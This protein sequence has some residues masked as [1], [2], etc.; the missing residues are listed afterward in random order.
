V[1][2]WDYFRRKER[3]FG[4][5]P[6]D[7]PLEE[8][9]QPSEGDDKRGIIEGHLDLSPLCTLMSY[10]RIVIEDESDPDP[11]AAYCY[12]LVRGGFHIHRWE[13]DSR[14]IRKRRSMSMKGLKNGA[15]NR[16]TGRVCARF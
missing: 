6:P 5:V 12:T 4:G 8:M 1:D 3:E 14:T 16:H 11:R 7:R 9:M 2:I 15:A 13:D 10:E